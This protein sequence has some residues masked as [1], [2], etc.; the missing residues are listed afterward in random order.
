M[1]ILR[2]LFYSPSE[3]PT[4]RSAVRPGIVQ[5]ER[6]SF[7]SKEIFWKGYEPSLNYVYIGDSRTRNLFYAHT[8]RLGVL[9]PEQYRDQSCKNNTFRYSNVE[10]CEEQEQG[11]HV[12]DIK[13]LYRACWIYEQECFKKLQTK[14]TAEK[15]LQLEDS[16]NVHVVL[17]I[18]LHDALYRYKEID[19]FKQELNK[20][21][22]T[23][24][25]L[26]VRH[27]TWATMFPLLPPQSGRKPKFE[28]WVDKNLNIEMFTRET[29]MLAE[30]NKVTLLNCTQFFNH[31]DSR[32]SHDTLHLLD[33][34]NDRLIL[35]ILWVHSEPATRSIRNKL[36]WEHSQMLNDSTCG[37]MHPML[38][39]NMTVAFFGGSVT[40]D[41][42]IV[43]AFNS[44]S[45]EVLGVTTRVINLGEAATTSAYQSQCMSQTLR[46]TS[47]DVVVIEYCVND[48]TEPI[49]TLQNLFQQVL[50]LPSDPAVVYY[51]HRA[52][53][54]RFLFSNDTVSRHL[55][56]AHEY[57]LMTFTNTFMLHNMLQADFPVLFRDN[58]HLTG[59]GGSVVARHLL[60]SIKQCSKE[61]SSLSPSQYVIRNNATTLRPPISCYTALGPPEHRNLHS[62]IGK[63]SGWPFIE[64][65]HQSA[66]NGKN[67][68]ESSK[69]GQCL[70]ISLHFSC[71]ND[72]VSMF[73]L[74]SAD[75]NMTEVNLSIH[76]CP[77]YSQVI[78]GRAPQNSIVAR[79][80]LNF[81]SAGNCCSAEVRKYS[82]RVCTARNSQETSRF[83]LVAISRSSTYA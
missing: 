19:A 80:H 5:L 1:L 78:S 29:N 47:V 54:N 33:R 41:G 68:Y 44:Q 61:K 74:A 12:Q 36:W 37:L 4:T 65:S 15:Y 49:S 48:A 79:R 72:T 30:E 67:G 71:A 24:V 6:A 13:I 81:T 62:L 2:E 8:R 16:S 27:L 75:P 53:R 51:C 3:R 59:H 32:L 18:G 28:N 17:N 34:V 70:D 83:R 82:I 57:G 14:K 10:Y 58:T 39:D 76:A 40:S 64:Q 31:Q 22:R 21:L 25:A 7:G 46:T 69:A 45:L 42:K 43:R 35:E 56:L 38:R 26:R 60:K 23:L 11:V 20:V 77:K 63:A 52:P 9:S 55:N 50:A 66:L 73:Y